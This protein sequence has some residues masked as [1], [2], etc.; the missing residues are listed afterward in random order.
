[1]SRKRGYP[2]NIWLI[3]DGRAW[4]GKDGGDALVYE[5]CRT[6]IEAHEHKTRD[7]PDGR[8]ERV[9]QMEGSRHPPYYEHEAWEDW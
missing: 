3:Y 5:S 2:P 9:R 8:V 6:Q 1:M 7:W 4:V